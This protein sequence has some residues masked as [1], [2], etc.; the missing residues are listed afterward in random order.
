VLAAIILLACTACRSAPTSKSPPREVI[1]THLPQQIQGY[2]IQSEVFR[3]LSDPY[4]GKAPLP[5]TYASE[6][7]GTHLMLSDGKQRA[8]IDVHIVTCETGM[9]VR[10]HLVDDQVTA[11]HVMKRATEDHMIVL[12]RAYRTDAIMDVIPLRIAPGP[13]VVP[14]GD[15]PAIQARVHSASRRAP[16]G[17]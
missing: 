16:S 15:A 3:D 9:E 17:A 8:V 10:F 7:T 12:L 6:V 13:D 14:V 4:A 2:W 5:L 1:N 11:Y